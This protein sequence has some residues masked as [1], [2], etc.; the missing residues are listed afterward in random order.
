M[1]LQP[2]LEASW[3]IQVHAF[4]AWRHLGFVDDGDCDV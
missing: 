2:L 3:V 4:G 1:S